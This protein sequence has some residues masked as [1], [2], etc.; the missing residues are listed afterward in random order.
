[1]TCHSDSGGADYLNIGDLADVDDIVVDNDGHQSGRADWVNGGEVH[2]RDDQEGG[3]SQ[4]G[5]GLMDWEEQ[6]QRMSLD[7]RLL[8]ELSSVGLLPVQPVSEEFITDIFCLLIS[9]W[10]LLGVFLDFKLGCQ[11]IS[12]N[13]QS[14]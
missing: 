14:L 13:W 12:P 6:Y 1:L 5:N 10:C 4:I 9:S 8:L 2:V 11:L 7:D 3:G